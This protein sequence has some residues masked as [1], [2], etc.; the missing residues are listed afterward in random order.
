MSVFLHLELTAVQRAHK[1][2][3]VVRLHSFKNLREGDQVLMGNMGLGEPKN[4]RNVIYL[5]NDQ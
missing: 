1:Q 3:A 4:K 5:V 2:F